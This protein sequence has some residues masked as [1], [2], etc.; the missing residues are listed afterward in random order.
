MGTDEPLNQVEKE[1][2]Q[3]MQPTEH[4]TKTGYSLLRVKAETKQRFEQIRLERGTNLTD[5]ELL[6]LLLD[7]RGQRPTTDQQSA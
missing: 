7:E 6:T 4:Q 5:D 2:S 3:L 1:G